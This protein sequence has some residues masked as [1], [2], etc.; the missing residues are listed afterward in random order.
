MNNHYDRKWFFDNGYGASVIQN[1]FS[2]GHEDGL[3]ELAVL[4]GDELE[5]GLCYDTP[6]TID[7][8]GWLTPRDVVGLL[9]QIK[10]LQ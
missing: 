9:K 4:K 10:E 2:Y 5:W 6:I 8:I 3:Y 7:V 1:Q